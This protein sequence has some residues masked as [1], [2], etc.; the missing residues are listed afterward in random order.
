[1]RGVGGGDGGGGGGGGGGG[2]CQAGKKVRNRVP[3]FLTF[4]N[5]A[6]RYCPLCTLDSSACEGLWPATKIVGGPLGKTI[7]F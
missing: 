6:R 7:Y 1:M 5:S 4:G 2:I 3:R